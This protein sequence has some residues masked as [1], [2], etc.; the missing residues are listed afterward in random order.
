MEGVCKHTLSLLPRGPEVSHMTQVSHMTPPYHKGHRDMRSNLTTKKKKWVLVNMQL[1][2]THT[3]AYLL[4][5]VYDVEIN[6]SNER[7]LIAKGKRL[8]MNTHINYTFKS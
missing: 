3:A 2:V 4:F 5:Y 8:H 6:L 7:E 1:S